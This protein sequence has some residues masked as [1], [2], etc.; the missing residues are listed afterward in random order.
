MH[1]GMNYQHAASSPQEAAQ[2]QLFGRIPEGLGVS[3]VAQINDPHPKMHFFKK[4]GVEDQ[5]EVEG[6]SERS[7]QKRGQWEEK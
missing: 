6:E 4:K 1:E 2:A 5:I 3:E 7:C